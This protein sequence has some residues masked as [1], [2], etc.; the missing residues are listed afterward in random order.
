MNAPLDPSDVDRFSK[1]ITRRLGLQFED[2]RLGL[3]REVLQRRLDALGLASGAY[4]RMLDT[5]ACPDELGALASEL[6]IPETYFFRNNQQFTA[7][8]EAVLP[9]RMQVQAMTRTLR[10]LC[11]ACASGEEAYS[12][13]IVAREAIADPSWTMSVRAVDLNPAVLQKAARARY[14]TWALRETSDE[15]RRRWF[16]EDG[17]EVILDKSIVRSVDFEPGNLATDDGDVWR[18][19]DYDVIFCRNVLMYFSPEQARAAV[20]RLANALSPGG[21]LFLGHAETLRGVSDDFHLLHTHDAFYYQRKD[22]LDPLPA[23]PAAALRSITGAARPEPFSQGWVDSIRRASE[24]VEA[25]ALARTVGP[26]VTL[27][28][29]A[30]RDL[31]P[32]LDLVREERFTEALAHVR[33]QRAQS[34]EDPDELLLE[35]ILLAHGGEYSAA[36]DVCRRLLASEELNAGAHYVL[37][38]CRESL[39][40]RDGAAEHDRMAVYLDPAFAMPRLHLGLLARRAGDR[41]TARAELGEALTLLDREE[42]S[43]VL[44]FGGGF[45]REALI[46]LCQSALRDCGGRP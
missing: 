42:A 33:D 26:W 32:A 27:S 28:A 17:R 23:R 24:R 44:L 5:K 37:A 38:L 2:A 20:A 22:G 14:S 12:I 40:D 1:A 6:T 3:L 45:K 7:L 39:G 18:R 8:A 11:A 21:Y 4:L 16:R 15:A 43:R 35:A 29:P 10:I 19:G 41:Q 9:D 25:L 13:A 31:G 36:E 34:A 46:D 30:R